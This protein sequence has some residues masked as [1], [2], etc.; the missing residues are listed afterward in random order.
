MTAPLQPSLIQGGPA[1]AAAAH[2]AQVAQPEP[3]KRKRGRPAGSRNSPKAVTTA[4]VGKRGRK[5]D[6]RPQARVLRPMIVLVGTVLMRAI[7]AGDTA[8]RT[9]AL[10]ELDSLTARLQAIPA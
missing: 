3:T 5:S 9:A 4:P 2:I 10:A 8:L 1:N 7:K 6:K